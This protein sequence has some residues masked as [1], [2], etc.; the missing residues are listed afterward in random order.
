MIN[1]TIEEISIE[2]YK[3]LLQN[4][5]INPKQHKKE[6]FIDCPENKKEFILAAVLDELETQEIVK[7][8]ETLEDTWWVLLKDLQSYPQA[9]EIDFE[10]KLATINIINK[11]CDKVGAPEQKTNINEFSGRDFQKLL[12]IVEELLNEKSEN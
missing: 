5:S 9:V 8:I 6:I 3:F 7:K 2:I 10:S 4:K 1:N 11:Y 12:V